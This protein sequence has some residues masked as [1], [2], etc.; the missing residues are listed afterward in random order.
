M[1]TRGFARTLAFGAAAGALWPLAFAASCRMVG[2]DFAWSLGLTGIAAAYAA[3]LAPHARGALASAG[4]VALLGSVIQLLWP[5]PLAAAGSAALSIAL[6]R[7]HWLS[8][9]RSGLR[10]L[11][12]EMALLLG[13]LV[14]AR[15]AFSPDPLGSAAAL[16]AYFL[17]QSLFF[18]LSDPAP[19][20]PAPAKGDPFEEALRRANTLLDDPGGGRS[21]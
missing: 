12:L 9:G 16:W 3:G 14:A 4:F 18:L 1:S 19:L 13:G 5:E 15:T 10:T 20:P 21:P 6:L 7:S 17:V 11:C 2:W 8:T